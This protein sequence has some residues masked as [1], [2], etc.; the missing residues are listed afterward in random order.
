MIQPFTTT[1]A[2][3]IVPIVT[4]LLSAFASVLIL[5]VIFKSPQKLST[6]Y[7]R[8]MAFMSI[9]D[10]I[11]S[12]FIALGTIMMPSDNVYDFEGPMLG[13]QVT[14][15]IQGW[16]VTFGSSG[17]ASLYMCLS[18]YFVSKLA[19]R[20]DSKRIKKCFEPIMYLYSVFM[21]LFL[22]SYYLSKD[23][24][25]P[26]PSHSYCTIAPYPE[27]CD[28]NVWRW[29]LCEWG[30]NKKALDDKFQMKDI[31]PVAI[32]VF[33]NLILVLIFML[34][35]LWTVYDNHQKVKAACVQDSNNDREN[36]E[37]SCIDDD[38]HTEIYIEQLRYSQVMS[39][40][41][42]MY[43]ASFFLTWIFNIADSGYG[44]FNYIMDALNA[45][46]FPMQGFWNMIIFIYDKTY[47]VY[48]INNDCDSHWK[49]IK[50]VFNAPDQIQDVIILNEDF[51]PESSEDLHSPI[52]EMET[53]ERNESNERQ[54][55]NKFS[56]QSVDEINVASLVPSEFQSLDE[57]SD[58]H[59]QTHQDPAEH[60]SLDP[61]S[62][63]IESKEGNS[64]A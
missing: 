22:A 41:A 11:A 61:V 6:T 33:T 31:V 34:I 45:T 40:Q 10:I 12:V 24:L 64:I 2:G 19:F 38:I 17:G 7:H 30:L 14:C 23:L 54:S 39:I 42:T 9:F 36:N 8:I 1:M 43:I 55:S 50:M 57:M 35:I 26:D 15:Q 53:E 3:F 37:T 59:G 27:F 49:A 46:F 28:E 25:H 18:W 48:Q 21:S 20:V 51:V 62:V 47:F 16:L 52:G 32:M 44:K 5:Y 56:L 13:N 29:S 63:P 4:G 60:I 58:N